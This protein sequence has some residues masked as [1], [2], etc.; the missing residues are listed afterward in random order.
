MFFT[1]GLLLG[2]Q[3]AIIMVKKLVSAMLAAEKWEKAYS[4]VCG[5]VAAPRISIAVVI[6]RSYPSL[7]SVDLVFRRAKK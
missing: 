5:F 2:K 1:D 7:L 4:E 3:E 6:A